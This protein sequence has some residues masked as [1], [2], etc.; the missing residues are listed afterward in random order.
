MGALHTYWLYLD[1]H[2]IQTFNIITLLT[3]KGIVSTPVE[4]VLAYEKDLT[5]LRR[6]PSPPSTGNEATYFVS[7]AHMLVFIWNMKR[8][9][10]T[11]PRSYIMTTTHLICHSPLDLFSLSLCGQR[12]VERVVAKVAPRSRE[13]YSAVSLVLF[14]CRRM[15]LRSSCV[16]YYLIFQKSASKPFSSI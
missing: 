5:W 9:V 1:V 3:V 6:Y 10:L 13:P 7:S 8:V 12:A 15:G 16:L 11:A 2:Q 14:A 4:S